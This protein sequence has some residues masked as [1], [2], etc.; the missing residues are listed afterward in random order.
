MV[1]S[2][3]GSVLTMAIASCCSSAKCRR[4][5]RF[6]FLRVV[7]RLFVRWSTSPLTAGSR[8]PACSRK[9]WRRCSSVAAV[10][11]DS[12]AVDCCEVSLDCLEA[13]AVV[14]LIVGSAKCC[15]VA[16]GLGSIRYLA[17]VG[18]V[19]ETERLL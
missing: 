3:A 11:N 14:S 2:T 9:N 6:G 16:T 4:M 18:A 8:A 17:V 1:E 7:L 10:K 12:A 15:C 13:F 5:S 19:V